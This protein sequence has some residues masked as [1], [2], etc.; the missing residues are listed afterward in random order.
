LGLFG[1]RELFDT[2][3]DA[4]RAYDTAVWRLKPREAGVYANFKDSCPPDVAEVLKATDKVGR[5]QQSTHPTA[6]S[7]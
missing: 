6:N 3:L 5:D 1:C 2:E 4:A 7:T